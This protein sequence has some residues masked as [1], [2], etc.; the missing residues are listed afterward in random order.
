MRDDRVRHHSINLIQQQSP[1]VDTKDEMVSAMGYHIS[2]QLRR[3]SLATL[4][5]STSS[6]SDQMSRSQHRSSDPL[7]RSQHRSS[8]PLSRSQHSSSCGSNHIRVVPSFSL[9]KSNS[10]RLQPRSS[11]LNN[12]PDVDEDI[13]ILDRL[14]LSSRSPGSRVLNKKFPDWYPRKSNDK[15]RRKTVSNPSDPFTIEN[16]L[17]D[18]DTVLQTDG[19]HDK[20]PLLSGAAKNAIDA[21]CTVVEDLFE[22]SFADD[23]NDDWLECNDNINTPQDS[24]HIT[25]K[26]K[27]MNRDSD[28]PQ[29]ME[30]Y[31]SD[32]TGHAQLDDE[33][34]RMMEQPR[35]AKKSPRKNL[36]V[37]HMRI[38]R[39]L[40]PPMRR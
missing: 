35:V 24:N 10:F 1:T 15:N 18:M 27:A 26:V 17:F 40:A 6:A 2:H 37:A 28:T 39:K 29:Q 32:V 13:M 16:V 22:D 12:E 7:S 11:Q 31:N 3:S 21:T 30:S 36:G 25:S 20:K 19:K 4:T 9:S 38:A 23:R 34:N 8:D 14:S 5:S 33:Q